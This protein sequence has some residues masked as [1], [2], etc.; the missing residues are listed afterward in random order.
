MRN[1]LQSGRGISVEP[2]DIS[3]LPEELTL[4]PGWL[5]DQNR[6]YTVAK[7][8]KQFRT[9]NE[10]LNANEWPYRS[11]WLL[12]DKTWKLIESNCHWQSLKEPRASLPYTG[13]V[14]L[15]TRF[16]RTANP[17]HQKRA[18]KAATPV[19]GVL[20]PSENEQR[21]DGDLD[22]F[23]REIYRLWNKVP[24]LDLAQKV[25]IGLTVSNGKF[26]VTEG[27]TKFK[28]LIDQIAKC[29]SHGLGWKKVVGLAFTTIEIG[30]NVEFPS[31]TPDGFTEVFAS[32]QEVPD[33]A[34]MCDWVVKGYIHSGI[35]ARGAN[36]D[37]CRRTLV[38]AGFPID[39]RPAKS[40]DSIDVEYDPCLVQV[41]CD[42][43]INFIDQA[44]MKHN[45][46]CVRVTRSDDFTSSEGFN[47]A[48]KNIHTLSDVVWYSPPCTGGSAWQHVN[49]AEGE[50]TRTKI[51]EQNLILESLE[52]LRAN[53]P[54]H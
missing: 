40:S 45:I 7:N 25:M 11:T 35:L 29:V 20:S 4:G 18:A 17:Q 49:C 48:I 32:A 46:R 13:A 39:S 22:L 33:W 47:K 34:D 42:D 21:T 14:K 16:E 1:I 30:W 6:P 10:K 12:I 27:A 2:D 54:A 52:Q 26:Q 28:P 9:P 3:A 5:D 15:L 36:P 23:H 44:C 24:P 8:P 37:A 51:E 19:E 41:C 38:Q 31:E 53:V 43:K 50:E